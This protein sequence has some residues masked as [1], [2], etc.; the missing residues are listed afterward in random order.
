MAHSREEGVSKAL[1]GIRVLDLTQWLQGPVCA[2]YLADFGAQVI[3]VERPVTGDGARGVRSIKALPV[4]DWNQYFLVI[5]RNKKSIAIDL[6]KEAGRDLLCDLAAKADVFLSN[7]PIDVL[8]GLG[9]TYEKL[10][11]IN[12]GLIY[13]TNTGY[14]HAVEV[15]RPSY[16]INVQALTGIMTRQGE[17]GQ[18]PIYLGMGSGDTYGGIMSAFG[19][20]LALHQRR[21]TGRGQYIDASL[22]GAQLFMGAP[23]LQPFLA[24]HNPF[25]ARQQSRKNARN[26]LWNRYQAKDK[27]LF[28]CAE[29]TDA[30]WSK[31]CGT[32]DAP[33]T[34]GD[35][36]FSSPESRAENHV[37]LV[38]ALGAAIAETSAQEWLDR[39]QRVGLVAS[40]IQNLKELSEDPQAWQNDYLMKTHCNEVDREVEIRGLPVTLSKT[41][42]SVETLGPE[43]G[44][45]TEIL[46]MEVLEMEWDRIEELKAE[47][48]IP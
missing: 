44:Q 24:S 23:T 20:L 38:E 10:S 26:P 2:Q 32:L 47:G 34:S 8:R 37:T 36:R 16:D 6:K 1:E 14:G 41:P 12:P 17:P 15:N 46:L 25:Y 31:L 39:W 22:Y 4:G 35:S 29:N 33:D 21:R 3:H 19:I 48:V 30:N 42:G 28:L 9:L 11:E 27:W 18:P 5:N 13:A 40:P 7:F 45:D 43:L